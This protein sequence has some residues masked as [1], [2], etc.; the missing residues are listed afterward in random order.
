MVSL[1]LQV[2]KYS[3]MYPSNQRK[4][5]SSTEEKQLLNGAMVFISLALA[6]GLLIMAGILD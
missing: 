1:R 4:T 3:L 2:I 5:R 6:I